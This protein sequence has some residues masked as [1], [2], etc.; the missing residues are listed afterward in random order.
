MNVNFY[1]PVYTYIEQ[2]LHPWLVQEKIYNVMNGVNI[3]HD[4]VIS[5]FEGSINGDSYMMGQIKLFEVNALLS[6]NF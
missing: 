5:I 4:D 6:R 2:D 3:E 1:P